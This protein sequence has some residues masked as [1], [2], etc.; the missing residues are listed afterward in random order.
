MIVLAQ[1]TPAAHHHEA[2]SFLELTV[3][4]ATHQSSCKHREDHLP[5][6][7][8]HHFARLW[9][10]SSSTWPR[11]AF[12]RSDNFKDSFACPV[13]IN[14]EA[15]RLPV[16]VFAPRIESRA[17]IRSS[18]LLAGCGTSRPRNSYVL[19]VPYMNAQPRISNRQV[20]ALLMKLIVALATY[21]ILARDFQ[22]HACVRHAS[23]D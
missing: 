4:T 20:K 12:S 17:E 16:V 7:G 15:T 19:C 10:N 18:C 21:G 14:R 8:Y 3:C 11:H 9:T 22:P 2:I 13:S 6:T 5:R 23:L 1:N